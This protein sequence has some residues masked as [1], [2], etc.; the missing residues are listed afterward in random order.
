MPKI[1]HRAFNGWRRTH[2]AIQ[3]AGGRILQ[4]FPVKQEFPSVVAWRNSCVGAS[5]FKTEGRRA[6]GA[7][8]R[9]AEFGELLSM[10]YAWLIQGA[11]R[12]SEDTVQIR[13]NDTSTG[14][15]TRSLNYAEPPVVR[16][17]G[18]LFLDGG[19]YKPK[20][21]CAHWLSLYLFT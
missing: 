3:L 2:T 16:R 6:T 19:K 17:E 15:I 8:R 1:T 7:A 11:Q 10:D 5:H 13:F 21:S 9:E 14:A 18:M 4:V 20:M 12:I